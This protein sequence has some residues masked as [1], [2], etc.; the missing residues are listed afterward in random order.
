MKRRSSRLASSNVGCWWTESI[1]PALMP[2]V[3]ELSTN[4]LRRSDARVPPT[5]QLARGD[6]TA[7]SRSV[8]RSRQL[9]GVADAVVDSHAPIC[10][11]RQKQA[12]QIAQRLID[13]PQPGLVAH[14]VLGNPARPLDDVSKARGGV[15]LECVLQL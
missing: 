7:C 14:V 15:Y 12:G 8:Q 11:A 6:L 10:V 13:S 3:Q 1:C 2:R 4:L 9:E 5:G